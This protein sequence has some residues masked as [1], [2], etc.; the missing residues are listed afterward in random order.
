[1][2]FRARQTF[3]NCNIIA[4]SKTFSW[5]LTMLPNGDLQFDLFTIVLPQE[6]IDKPYHSTWLI[7]TSFLAH[8]TYGIKDRI[9]PRKM[10]LQG[11]E[12]IFGYMEQPF[13]S[14]A[15]WRC[16]PWWILVASL[17]TFRISLLL[18]RCMLTKKISV[19]V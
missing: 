17:L 5:A 4:N 7:K 1:M 10:L 16:P 12:P 8:I 11:A 2:R 9:E 13:L 6:I 15:E 14:L 18:S 3:H 19:T